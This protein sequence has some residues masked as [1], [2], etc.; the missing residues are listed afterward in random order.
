MPWSDTIPLRK[1][2]ALGSFGADVYLP[3]RYGVTAGLCVRLNAAGTRWLW[4]DHACQAVDSVRLDGLRITGWV[5][6]NEIDASG[7]AI[8]VVTLTEKPKGDASVFATGRGKIGLSNP[9]DVA[10]DAL[11]ITELMPEF[12]SECARRDYIAGGSI[13]EPVTYQSLAR[14][15]AASF[16]AKFTPAKLIFYPDASTP[17]AADIGA[18]QSVDKPAGAI[19]ANFDFADGSA[20]QTVTM[21]TGPGDQEY[22]DLTWVSSQRV[23]IAVCGALSIERSAQKWTFDFTAKNKRVKA[24]DAVSIAVHPFNATATVTAATWLSDSTGTAELTTNAATVAT[25]V[26]Q[27]A[28]FDPDAGGD[29]TIERIGNNVRLLVKDQDTGAPLSNAKCTLDER[30]TRYTDAAGAVTFPA[31]ALAEGV[32]HS[33]LVEQDGRPAFIISL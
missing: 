13:A 7:R 14:S 5:W 17:I 23:A 27:S 10:R 33:V 2:S 12:R 4:A 11:G 29:V 3:S 18:V 20:R 30:M 8:C 16:G 32:P 6:A 22:A 24:G 19:T 31:S 15:I 26:H 21:R 1:S 9:A 28:K 25:L